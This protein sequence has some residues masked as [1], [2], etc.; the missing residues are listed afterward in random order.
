[1]VVASL[2][3]IIVK[4]LIQ[5]LQLCSANLSLSWAKKMNLTELSILPRKIK[6]SDV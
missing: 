2:E 6:P 3:I 5:Y 1:M 4:A